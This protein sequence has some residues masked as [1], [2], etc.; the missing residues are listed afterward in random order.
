[1][2][3]EFSQSLELKQTL[4]LNQVMIQRFNILQQSSDEFAQTLKEE[5]EKNPFINV[6]FM[7][8]ERSVPAS[9][10]NDDYVTPID[11]ATYDESLLSVLTNQLEY[12][13]ISETAYN[14]VLT[15]I[16]HCDS[17]GFIKNY[18]D[19]CAEIMNEFGVS[20]QEVLK[21]LKLLQSFDPEGVG[22][23]SI[24]ECLWIQIDNY[25]LEDELD[26]D[27]LQLLVKDYLDHLSEKNY[28]VILEDLGISQE[29]L[30]IYIEFISHLSPSPGHKYKSSDVIHIQ[31]SLKVD[32]ND[33][34]ITVKNLEE[35][36][37]SFNLNQDLLKKLDQSNDPTL[38]KQ[39]ADAKVWMEHFRKR[40]DLLI[41]CGKYLIEKQR[42]YFL[43]GDNY[44]VPC[45]QKQMA[46]DM[47]VSESTISRLV[48]SKYIE[49]DGGV[50]LA[51][52]LCQRGIYGK[53]VHQ[54]KHL[55]R[56]YCDRYPDLSDQKISELLKSIGLPLARRTVNKYRHETSSSD[57]D[58]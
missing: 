16:D 58:A 55:V 9:I 4:K 15:L 35:E 24:N 53:T 57:S 54:V 25:D 19:V 30:D 27:N 51:Q 37:I 40:Q 33:G 38:E 42:L 7:D 21:G 13:Q 6:R 45:L 10:S 12:Q 36:R 2:K 8:Q 28:D 46:K 31:P 41:N 44:I 39:L 29:Q 17:V 1:M 49:T 11:Y 56:Y 3:L 20:K 14:V 5:S 47:G 34:V 18:S 26:R 48:R 52:I 22:A 23:R 50:I 32:V 43:E